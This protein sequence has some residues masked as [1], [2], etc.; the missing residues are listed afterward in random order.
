MLVANMVQIA[1]YINHTKGIIALI[2]MKQS[3][4]WL[5]WSI[6][7]ERQ[8]LQLGLAQT[9]KHDTRYMLRYYVHVF[10]TH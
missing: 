4:R 1:K 7:I 9:A 2:P 5:I 8:T 3:W 6:R 10:L